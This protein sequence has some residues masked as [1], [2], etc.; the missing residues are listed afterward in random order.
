MFI[1]QGSV[2]ANFWGQNGRQYKIPVQ[3]L[4]GACETGNY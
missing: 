1:Y 2:V 4:Q 3:A